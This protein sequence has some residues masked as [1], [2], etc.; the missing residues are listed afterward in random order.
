MKKRIYLDTCCYN[1]RFDDQKQERIQKEWNAIR[2]IISPSKEQPFDI[3]GSEAL[4]Y[5]VLNIRDHDRRES[6]LTFY[7]NSVIMEL[8]LTKEAIAYAKQLRE[9]SS[10]KLLDSLHVALAEQSSVSALLT[11]DERM[12]RTCQK[13]KLKLNV[14]NP[15]EFLKEVNRNDPT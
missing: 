13:L 12:L 4:K 5:E 3:I 1:R 8:P 9:Q 2:A 7:R 10:L 15:I 14:M 11:T 6:V